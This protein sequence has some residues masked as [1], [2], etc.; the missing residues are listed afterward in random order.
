MT[1]VFAADVELADAVIASCRPRPWVLSAMRALQTRY[2]RVSADVRLSTAASRIAASMGNG[3]PQW[4][5]ALQEIS[6]LSAAGRIVCVLST[7]HGRN[8]CGV[9]Y[10]DTLPMDACGEG[11]RVLLM[12]N[13][14]ATTVTL[15]DDRDVNL[16]QYWVLV[17]VPETT[18]D[19]AP[20][21]HD[22][23]GAAE[24][25]TRAFG[26]RKNVRCRREVV[27]A[28]VT[29]AA[30]WGD[31][32]VRRIDRLFDRPTDDMLERA[33]HIDTRLCSFA[34]RVQTPGCLERK[35]RARN[36]TWQALKR[37]RGH[38]ISMAVVMDYVRFMGMP[39]VCPLCKTIPEDACDKCRPIDRVEAT[40][41][42]RYHCR[43]GYAR[44]E[45]YHCD[46]SK[47]LVTMQD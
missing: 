25:I 37:N 27:R 7:S 8:G 9:G 44:Y 13:P 12:L 21:L 22:P 40:R 5:C 18:S 16:F 34:Q 1:G 43:A 45:A 31:P 46:E 3:A 29:V 4:V 2:G 39:L 15:S 28:F 42:I 35:V 24:A 30:S 32:T 11:Q 36:I 19:G 14:L 41:A 6:F 23:A 26:G 38:A 10:H 17:N 33:R 47:W 20:L